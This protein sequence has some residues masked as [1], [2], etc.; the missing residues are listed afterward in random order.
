MYNSD[1]YT[2]L[3]DLQPKP[4]LSHTGHKLHQFIQCIQS[5]N[6]YQV[7]NDSQGLVLGLISGLVYGEGKE[8]VRVRNEIL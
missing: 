2:N 6:V 3:W 4:V 1:L 5:V 7:P 8:D